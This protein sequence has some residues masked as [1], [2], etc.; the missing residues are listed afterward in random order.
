MSDLNKIETC[1]CCGSHSFAT[2]PVLWTKLINEWGLSPDEAEYI[3]RQQGVTC[4]KCGSNLRSIALAK[5]ILET[6]ECRGTFLRFILSPRTWFLRILEINSAGTLTKY[7]SR[8]PRRTLAT[9]PEVDMQQMPYESN[10]FDLIVHSDT[11]EHVPDPVQGLSECFR[12]LR[13]G[14]FCCFTI[15]II[16]GRPTRTRSG[17]APSHHGADKDNKNDYLVQTEYG[18]DFWLQLFRAGFME[19]R[20]VSVEFP[21]AQAIIARKSY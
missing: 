3:D 19:C 16:I 15:P 1:A 5:A 11:L 13:P 4:K 20:I 10:R 9:Y 8:L 6:R 18:D 17:L 7:L 21:S 12:V 14:G 2:H